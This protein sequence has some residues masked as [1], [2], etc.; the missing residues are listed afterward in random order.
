MS[1]SFYIG[2]AVPTHG[3][4]D[5]E[6]FARWEVTPEKHEAFEIMPNDDMTSNGNDR[7]PAYI[8]WHEFCLEAGIEE[9][10][11]DDQTGFVSQHPGCFLLKRG[12]LLHVQGRL[13]HRRRVSDK[14]P[15]FPT[16]NG[17]WKIVDADKYDATLARLI[18]LEYWMRWA[19]ENCEIPAIQNT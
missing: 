16:Y 17:D 13:A 3:I 14:P 5:G 1:Y 10:F 15:G 2:N 4:E 6:L 19:L 12:H 18:W 11:Y 9:M 8:A 7:Y